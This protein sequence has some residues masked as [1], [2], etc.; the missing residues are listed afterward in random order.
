MLTT[1]GLPNT[2]IMSHNYHSFFV[3]RLF[4]I[5][6]L[7]TFQ[8]I[9]QYYNYNHHVIYLRFPEPVHLI[10]LTN[11]YASP[12]LGP[13]TAI[14]VSVSMSSWNPVFFVSLLSLTHRADLATLWVPLLRSE[15]SP[16]GGNSNPFQYFCL[17]NPI[18]KGAWQATVH[19]VSKSQTQLSNW[20]HTHFW[21]TPQ[22]IAFRR[23]FQ[24]WFPGI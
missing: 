2:S 14:V 21:A 5:C 7:A 12:H 8:Y 18:D 11:M 22:S 19:G 13:C 1:V 17:K 9:T 20:A 6:S 16:R 15:R 10:T 23:T 24:T 3:V 4:K